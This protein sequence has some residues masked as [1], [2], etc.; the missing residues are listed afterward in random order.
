VLLSPLT[1]G[2]SSSPDDFAL[3][4]I[5]DMNVPTLPRPHLSFDKTGRAQAH[6]QLAEAGPSRRRSTDQAP[7]PDDRPYQRELSKKEKAAV[8]FLSLVFA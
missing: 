3:S 8:S 4:P 2:A 5:P 6:A 1:A 7:E